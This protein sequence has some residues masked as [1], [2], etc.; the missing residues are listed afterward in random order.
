MDI[1]YLLI[2]IHK[3]FLGEATGHSQWSSFSPA[4]TFILQG[5]GHA[6]QVGISQFVDAVERGKYIIDMKRLQPYACTGGGRT[7][8]AVATPEIHPAPEVQ[9]NTDML[10]KTD[11]A[12]IEL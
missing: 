1:S 6:D 2:K 8:I 4:E 7:G 10:V 3:T 11:T 9:F 5:E 12:Y